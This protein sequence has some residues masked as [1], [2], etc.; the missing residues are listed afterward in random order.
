MKP[1][2][3]VKNRSIGNEDMKKIIEQ[4]EYIK[5]NKKITD[6]DKLI[7]IIKNTNWDEIEPCVL[8]SAPPLI[9]T[10]VLIPIA[11]SVQIIK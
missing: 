2:E 6:V 1:C 10:P 4:Y 5:N 11:T 9:A 8:P 7:K 3:M